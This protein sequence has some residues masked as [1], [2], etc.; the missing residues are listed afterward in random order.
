MR[1]WTIQKKEIVDKIMK[2]GS[3]VPDFG[4]CDVN[5]RNLPRAYSFLLDIMNEVY[6]SKQYIRGVVFCMAPSFERAFKNPQDIA[7]HFT[8][9]S[10]CLNYMKNGGISLLDGDNIL[11]ELEYPDNFVFLDVDIELFCALDDCLCINTDSH[12]WGIQRGMIIGD[13]YLAKIERLTIDW[14]NRDSKEFLFSSPVN[15]VQQ[16]IPFITVE[17]ILNMWPVS[18]LRK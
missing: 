16:H 7:H 2:D 11:M 10:G 8:A 13:E 18:V 5:N 1:T 14:L 12:T 4:L 15:L 3:Y 17:N 6:R 9:N